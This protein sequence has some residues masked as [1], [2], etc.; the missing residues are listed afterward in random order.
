MPLDFAGHNARILHNIKDGGLCGKQIVCI[1]RHVILSIL[2]SRLESS[3]SAFRLCKF[4]PRPQNRGNNVA[5]NADNLLSVRNAVFD[6]QRHQQA[7]SQIW[8]VSAKLSV[9]YGA[10]FRFLVIASVGSILAIHSRFGGEYSNSIRWA[11]QG[12]YLEMCK[13]LFHSRNNIPSR[14]KLIMVI[15]I[16]ASLAASLADKG[17]SHFISASQQTGDLLDTIAVSSTQ[18]ASRTIVCSFSGWSTSINYG[19]DVQEAMTALISNKQNIPNM[20]PGRTYTPHTSHYEVGCDQWNITFNNAAYSYSRNGGCSLVDLMIPNL[21]N[22]DNATVVQ[23][24][25]EDVVWNPPPVSNGLALPPRTSIT[26]CVL[27]TGGMEI[28]SMSSIRLVAQSIQNFGN[29]TRTVFDEPDELIHS[30]EAAISNTTL[31]L[32]NM[33]FMELKTLASYI[34]AFVC[35]SALNQTALSCV[36]ITV[37]AFTVE[38]QETDPRLVET[39]GGKPFQP[40][41]TQ[42]T[43]IIVDYIPITAN[44]TQAPVPLSNIKNATTA[45]SNYMASLAYSFFSSYSE[46]HVYVLFD[47]AA[48]ENGFEVPTWLL[49][50]LA[51]AMVI[52]LC[53]W[54]LTSYFLNERYTGSL[55]NA[56]S[57][58]ISSRINVSAP[59]I[60]RSKV[61]PIEFEG[62]AILGDNDINKPS[63]SIPEV[64]ILPDNDLHNLTPCIPEVSVLPYNDLD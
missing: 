47:V 7:Y 28:I 61:I 49:I 48:T 60:M 18:F 22:Y 58:E 31:M 10:V 20:A 25:E 64:S 29:I 63:P 59:M 3:Q 6:V 16:T 51:V 17:A 57:M 14:A 4:E 24:S 32:H 13:A 56:I 43:R 37:D 55:Y 41:P 12:G 15:T 39:H 42:S 44:G 30:M 9:I 33:V 62:M 1:F 21:I 26:K 52:C 54:G 8:M 19:D 53:L 23:I 40:D 46:S 45:A 35:A 50:S 36:Y 27:D 34:E 11:R 38:P 2:S 5:V